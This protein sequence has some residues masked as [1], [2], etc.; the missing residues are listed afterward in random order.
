[1]KHEGDSSMKLK[2][3]LVLLAGVSIAFAGCDV[4]VNKSIRIEDGQEVHKSLSS[5]NGSIKIGSDCEVHG[6]AKTVNGSIRVGD[7]SKVEDL[8]TVNG[9][10]EIGDKVSVDGSMKTVNGR[11]RAGKDSEIRENIKTVNGSITLI[12]ATVGRDIL[13]HNGDITLTEGSVVSGDIVVNKS[14][15]F[16]IKTRR[17]TITLSG[18]SVV[19]GDI[20]IKDKKIKATVILEEGSEVKGEVRGATVEKR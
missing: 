20:N 2:G 6:N 13:T 14:G 5:V 17:M 18:K 8:S 11:V 15:G 7:G 12:G 3:L 19:E 1:M 16:S 9:R 10:V 4:S